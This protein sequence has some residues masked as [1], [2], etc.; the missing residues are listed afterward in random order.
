MLMQNQPTRR[1]VNYQIHQIHKLSSPTY[2][3]LLKTFQKAYIAA[4][5][6]AAAAA[7]YFLKEADLCHSPVYDRPLSYKK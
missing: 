7:S 1:F 6:A 2:E 5:A 3:Q 4:A